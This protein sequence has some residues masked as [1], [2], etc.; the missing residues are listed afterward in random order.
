MYP[1]SNTDLNTEKLYQKYGVEY[2]AGD[3]IFFEG[4]YGEDFYL[5][6]WGTVKVVKFVDGDMRV[7]R[8]LKKNSIFGEYAYF[9]GNRRTA[10][11]IAETDVGLVRINNANLDNIIDS[12]NSEI[13]LYFLTSF[14]ERIEYSFEL[15]DI[16]KFE[17]AEMKIYKYLNYMINLRKLP[18]N[19][20]ELYELIHEPLDKTLQIVLRWRDQH[21]LTINDGRIES[22][23][24]I[25]AKQFIN[26]M[27]NIV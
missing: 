7:L 20:C 3:I 5:V 10:T 25:T 22:F 11:I 17:T 21:V 27:K 18:V 8:L 26:R 13:I 9:S 6:Y 4:D 19:L 23:N 1:N 16:L 24:Y 12:N 14:S 15:L 2:K